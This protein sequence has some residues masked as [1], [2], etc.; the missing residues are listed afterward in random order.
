MYRLIA[1]LAFAL[2]PVVFL[3]A[4]GGNSV[5][6]LKKVEKKDVLVFL[7]SDVSECLDPHATSSGG[8]AFLIQQMY[9]TLVQPS[10]K[11]PVAWEPCLAES[12]TISEDFKTFTFKLRKG[13]K[14][15]DGAD[16]N[17]AAVK[18]SFERATNLNDPAAPPDL[19]YAAEY[20]GGIEKIEAL[21]EHTLRMTLKD[22]NPKFLAN[23][24]LFA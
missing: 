16:F 24:G 3:T 10:K 18:R 21:D 6:E 4:C 9:E 19:P 11:P 8:D 23:C 15:H 12:W 20:F 2:A 5:P 22:T 1:M 13:V 7:R 17:A 14:F